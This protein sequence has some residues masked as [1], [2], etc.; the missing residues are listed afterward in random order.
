[1]DV[2]CSAW[3]IL[4]RLSGVVC[5]DCDIRLLDIVDSIFM[6]DAVAVALFCDQVL[7]TS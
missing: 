6:M 2:A 4:L 1:M 5:I 3:A 7:R